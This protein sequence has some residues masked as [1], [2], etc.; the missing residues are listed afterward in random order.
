M[1]WSDGRRGGRR[2]PCPF[3]LL[4]WL[5]HW[6][7]VSTQIQQQVMQPKKQKLYNK[8]LVMDGL[9]VMLCIASSPGVGKLLSD[10]MYLTC[11]ANSIS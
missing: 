11:C 5:P 2:R 6:L 7:S 8:H 3:C 9:C 10:S 4:H 1:M